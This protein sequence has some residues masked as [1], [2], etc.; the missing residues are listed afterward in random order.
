MA[1]QHKTIGDN[2]SGGAVLVPG[3]DTS[4]WVQ[5][6]NHAQDRA[7]ERLGLDTEAQGTL[8]DILINNF[9]KG[10]VVAAEDGNTCMN[11]KY[12][13]KKFHIPFAKEPDHYYLISVAPDHA[14]PKLYS[15]LILK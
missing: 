5:V 3:I 1:I 13:G 8:I 7:R 2:I 10:T 6:S 14:N 9:R 11:I 15:R 12:D 4:K